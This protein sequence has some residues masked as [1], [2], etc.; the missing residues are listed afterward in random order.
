L[1]NSYKLVNL[2]GS[3]IEGTF[4][5][6]RLR[7]FIPREG[8]KLAEA[9]KELEIQLEKEEVERKERGEE[10]EECEEEDEGEENEGNEEEEEESA[11]NE[12]SGLGVAQRRGR[13][14]VRG[15]HMD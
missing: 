8:T 11:E 12:E 2:D 3:P 9:Q 6:R 7:V 5:S 13:R 1:R 14:F 10:D 4:S 15:G